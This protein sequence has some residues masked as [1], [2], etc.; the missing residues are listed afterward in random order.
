MLC[1]D[2][3]AHFFQF[4]EKF[5]R[6]SRIKYLFHLCLPM[7]FYVNDSQIQFFNRFESPLGYPESVPLEAIV[8]QKHFLYESWSKPHRR[9]GEYEA[10]LL[11]VIDFYGTRVVLTWGSMDSLTNGP[12][13][14]QDDHSSKAFSDRRCIHSNGPFGN[15]NTQK[16]LEEKEHFKSFKAKGVGPLLWTQERFFQMSLLWRHCDSSDGLS[17]W[18][19][20]AGMQGRRDFDWKFDAHLC[21]VQFKYGFHQLARIQKG[22]CTKMRVSFQG[23]SVTWGCLQSMAFNSKHFFVMLSVQ[24]DSF[25]S[26]RMDLGSSSR[27]VS[28]TTGTL[29]SRKK[30]QRAV[31]KI[32]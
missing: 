2:V 10:K 19:Y 28:D 7:G 1:K 8:G 3:V 4:L 29:A 21:N 31:S 30:T 15:Q 14:I 18:T 6:S 12:L 26:N 27:L 16:H 24:L 17:L 22:T 32:S 20:C 25:T 9:L 11:K 13:S 5:E 23:S